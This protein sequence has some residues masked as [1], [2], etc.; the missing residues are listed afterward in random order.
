MQQSLEEFVGASGDAVEFDEE[1]AEKQVGV[2]R[3]TK[4]ILAV[5][6]ILYTFC[7]RVAH[8]TVLAIFIQWY[9][10]ALS[11]TLISDSTTLLM[12]FLFINI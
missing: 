6:F 4:Q 9:F 10:C 11:A 5:F 8:T 12:M 1:E 7:L 2:Q 3:Q